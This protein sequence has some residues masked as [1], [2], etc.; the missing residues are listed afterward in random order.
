MNDAVYM[1]NDGIYNIIISYIIF[2][3]VKL[4]FVEPSIYYNHFETRFFN[5]KIF[6]QDLDLSNLGIVEYINWLI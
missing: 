6:S 1:K 2:F 5:N 3:L 4:I